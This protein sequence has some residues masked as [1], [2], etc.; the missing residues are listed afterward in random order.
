MSFRS[1]LTQTV[2]IKR[3]TRTPGRGGGRGKEY[4][5]VGNIAARIRPVSVNERAV[6]AQM[7]VD[8]SHILYCLDGVDIQRNDRVVWDEK[9]ADVVSVRRP[10]KPHHLEVELMERV[11]GL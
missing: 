7:G 3:V 10:S 4:D 11:K 5:P 1:L 6:A 2:E 9:E 8:A